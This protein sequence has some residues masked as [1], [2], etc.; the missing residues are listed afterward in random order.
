MPKPTLSVRS[1]SPKRVRYAAMMQ[2]TGGRARLKGKSMWNHRPERHGLE[3]A[4]QKLDQDNGQQPPA[5]F[6]GE[7]W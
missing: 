5:K 2:D 6:R 4:R 7:G 1:F 3:T